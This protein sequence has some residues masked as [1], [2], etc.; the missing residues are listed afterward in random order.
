MTE[1]QKRKILS[2]A[3]LVV[4][5]GALFWA[6]KA[7]EAKRVTDSAWPELAGGL[8]ASEVIRDGVTSLVP[9]DELYNS[10]VL[11]GGIPALTDPKYASVLASD[12]IIA[13]SLYGID[14]AIN[15]EH[16]FYPVQI[17][18][19]H[20]VVN[21]TWGGKDIAV[22]YC[23]LCATGI[24]YDRTVNGEAT[25]FEATGQVYNNNSILKDSKTGSL[26][27]QSLGTAVQG[28]AIGTSLSVIPSHMMT[29]TE[30]KRAYPSGLVLST[31]TGAIRDYTRHPYN[32]Y[33]SSKGMYF[34][35]NY[36]SSAFSA[37]WAVYGVTDGTNGLGFADVVLS[38][39]G[40]S[41]AA[42]GDED[43]IAVYDFSTTD[44]RVFQAGGR[45]FSF[46]FAK[47]RLTDNETG[48]VWN[49]AGLAISGPLRGESLAQ[50]E[51]VLGYWGCMAALHPTWIA[52]TAQETGDA[53]EGDNQE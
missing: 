4:V 3:G 5:V 48:S 36:T 45:T 22:T 41:A 8:Y 9:G 32:N 47:N 43:V 24:V 1:L 28:D 49:A 16:R 46:D 40:M 17:L 6:Y 13:D 2:F 51:V 39:V 19:W 37:K 27:V 25:T 42:L 44:V 14:L 11:E 7:Y 34:P 38:G 31:D 21:D 35:M 52:V 33:D 18:N 23:P 10:G 50:Y 53:S 15:G 12:A 29:W 20:G 30:W 26:W